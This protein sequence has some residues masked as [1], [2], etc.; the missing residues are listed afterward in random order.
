MAK[1]V[2]LELINSNLG[3]WAIHRHPSRPGGHEAFDDARYCYGWQRE[4]PG[5][6]R[7]RHMMTYGRACKQCGRGFPTARKMEELYEE[8]LRD[9]LGSLQ[10]VELEENAKGALV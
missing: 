10:R 9:G 5:R 7:Q 3:V 1:T 2:D 8:R 6:W 4:G